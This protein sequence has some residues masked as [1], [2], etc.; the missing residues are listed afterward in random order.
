MGS[1]PRLERS[2]EKEMETHSSILWGKSHGQRSLGSYSLWGHRELDTTQHSTASDK[3]YEVSVA[4]KKIILFTHTTEV[5]LFK[6]KCIL[7]LTLFMS[8]LRVLS[9]S[10]F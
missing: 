9:N 1:I 4:W 10:V 8:M 7:K 6:E 5:D 2:L 3:R